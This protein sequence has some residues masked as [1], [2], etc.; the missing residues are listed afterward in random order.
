MYSHEKSKQLTSAMSVLSH[1]APVCFATIPDLSPMRMT[2]S[3]GVLRAPFVRRVTSR[4][5]P[6]SIG[7]LSI[8]TVSLR[9][10]EAPELVWHIELPDQTG[11]ILID[12][13]F[14]PNGPAGGYWFSLDVR[15]YY[16]PRK[17]G[18]DR[19]SLVC[20]QDYYDRVGDDAAGYVRARLVMRQNPLT[21][22]P[23]AVT[24]GSVLVGR[25]NMALGYSG[26]SS[27]GLLEYVLLHNNQATD[28]SIKAMGKTM[29]KH[30]EPAGSAYMSYKQPWVWRVDPPDALSGAYYR[31]TLRTGVQPAAIC[32]PFTS[33]GVR[34][35][36][37][38]TVWDELDMLLSGGRASGLKGDAT[39]EARFGQAREAVLEVISWA[40][41]VQDPAMA[42]ANFRKNYSDT[43]RL[44]ERRL[45]PLELSA[46]HR[47]H[48]E[49]KG[50]PEARAAL[51]R[52]EAQ[53]AR[54]T[55][56]REEF[57]A[58][59][60]A[61]RAADPERAA[62]AVK[63]LDEAARSGT[64]LYNRKLGAHRAALAA[65]PVTWL[66]AL[67]ADWQ[68]RTPVPVLQE[69][70]RALIVARQ[71]EMAHGPTAMPPSPEEARE[72]ARQ[73]R[74]ET[75]ER[76]R[77]EHEKLWAEQFTPS[78]DYP[79]VNPHIDPEACGLV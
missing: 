36:A 17:Q 65:M 32:T 67:L 77:L 3:N 21:L 68:G 35:D 43:L 46:L 33:P 78:P 56:K 8:Q 69:F 47:L 38:Q 74:A 13:W 1:L 64:R 57:E 28:W 27:D 45:V 54:A 20:H 66:E 76:L 24:G 6:T 49:F 40:D 61:R 60:S 55:G 37:L 9:P 5:Y 39:P 44:L 19:L 63:E 7:G 70:E 42:R 79:V 31:V 23:E 14:V 73:R 15:S 18:R 29:G 48:A 16:D 72:L 12:G 75:E 62:K 51:H 52:I 25:P 26:V 4:K 34:R 71:H 10:G 50:R 30:A 22:A 58:L 11:R 53:T 59:E 41:M 2:E